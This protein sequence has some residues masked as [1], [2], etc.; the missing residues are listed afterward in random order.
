MLNE[1]F[2]HVEHVG[3]DPDFQPQSMAK[4]YFC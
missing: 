4:K 2:L 3:S 1:C